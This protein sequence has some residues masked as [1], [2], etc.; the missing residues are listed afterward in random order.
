MELYNLTGKES[1]DE[2]NA[3]YIQIF[4][5]YLEYGTVSIIEKAK[6]D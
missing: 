5:D 6:L 4:N 1:D 3:I 2:L